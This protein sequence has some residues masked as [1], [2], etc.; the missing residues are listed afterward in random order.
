[1]VQEGTRMTYFE[2]ERGEKAYDLINMT[3]KKIRDIGI[4]LAF[5]PEDRLGMGL[6]GNMDLSDNMMLRSFRRGRSVFTDRKSPRR[7]NTRAV[8]SRSSSPPCP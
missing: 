3:P 1:M 6:V 5:V 8:T 7:L 2:G 4:H